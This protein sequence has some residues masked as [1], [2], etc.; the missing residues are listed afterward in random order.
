M[1]ENRVNAESVATDLPA[2]DEAVALEITGDNPDLAR[3][4]VQMLMRGLPSGPLRSAALLLGQRLAAA[5][6]DR[7]P[8]ARHDQLLRCTRPRCPSQGVGGFR[9]GRRPGTHRCRARAGRA[10]SGT[11]DSHC[12]TD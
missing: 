9:Q 3:E 11:A 10:G 5:H 2:W 1:E 6:R 4:L 8:H 12:H 7:P